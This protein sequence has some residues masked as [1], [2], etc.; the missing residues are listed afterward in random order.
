M[1]TRNREQRIDALGQRLADAI[2]TPVVNAIPLPSRFFDGAQP[3]G[4]RLVGRAP[5]GA[6]AGA[7]I[8]R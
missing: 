6:A 1:Q 8:S 4:R 7:A 5:M 3:Q 2:R